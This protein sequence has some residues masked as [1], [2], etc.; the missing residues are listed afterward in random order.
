MEEFGPFYIPALRKKKEEKKCFR[1]VKNKT[2]REKAHLTLK[3]IA[4][5]ILHSRVNSTSAVA[6]HA[7]INYSTPTFRALSFTVGSIIL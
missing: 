7:A 4:L 5:P 2:L 1:K 3:P 6:R